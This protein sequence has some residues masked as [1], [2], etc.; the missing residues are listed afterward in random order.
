MTTKHNAAPMERRVRPEFSQ[1]ICE[2]GVAIL[3]DGRPMSISQIL[4]CLKALDFL[5]E[6]KEHKESH[7]NS[8]WNQDAMA[9]AWK[10]A[11][12]ANKA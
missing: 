4:D 3:K 8:D 1:G 11:N 5:I 9:I 6:I 7:W 10:I 2:D 12:Q